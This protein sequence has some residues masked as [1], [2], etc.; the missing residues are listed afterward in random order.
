MATE[1]KVYLGRD[2]RQSGPKLITALIDG[3]EAAG[4]SYINFGLLTTP[5]LHYIVRCV[6]TNN[7]YGDPSEEGYYQKLATAY[8]QLVELIG[9]KDNYQPHVVVDAANGVGALKL[10]RLV[11]YLLGKITL[12][13]IHDPNGVLNYQCGADYVKVNQREPYSVKLKPQQRYV[14]FDGDAD[15]II[16]YYQNSEDG[17]FHMLD[18]D[19]IAVLVAKFLKQT[20]A[21]IDLADIKVSIVQTAYANGSS[22]IYI[23]D[24]LGVETFCVAT[25]VKHL[26][27]KAEHCQIGVYFEANGHGTIL[28]SE[29]VHNRIEK[30][31]NPNAKQLLH[32]IDL[33]NQVRG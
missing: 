8:L 18:G 1:A 27:R 5:Q 3:I 6:N 20:L 25:G 23:G 29:E 31:L 13:I 24:I 12:D 28:F 30:S 32:F 33:V 19:K 2:T 11:P 4:G 7:Q 22:T 26:H 17:K 21:K 16:Y 10:E 15:R 14:S 9:P